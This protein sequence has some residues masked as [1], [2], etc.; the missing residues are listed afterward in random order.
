M[1]CFTG[2]GGKTTSML[3]LAACLARSSTVIVT[4]TTRMALE[5]TGPENVLLTKNYPPTLSPDLISATKNLLEAGKIVYLF[6]DMTDDKY[7]GLPPE[8]VCALHDMN[9]AKWI[10]AEADGA[11]RMPLKG[12]A[13][14]EPPLPASFDCQVVVVGADALTRPMNEFTTARFEILRRFLGVE[15]DAVLTPPLLLRLLT[16]PDMYLK[17]SP[18]SVK[19]VLCNNKS[20]LTAPDVL[21]PWTAYLRAHLSQYQGILVTGRDGE[22]FYELDF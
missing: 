20:N 16:S 6:Q 15:R 4:T 12:Y 17:N 19:R 5:E 8:E 7:V 21:A 14:Y 10:L 18:P 2:G 22:V 3:R 9:L 13:E 11:S 1:V